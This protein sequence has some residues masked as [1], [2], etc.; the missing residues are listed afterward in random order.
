M[1]GLRAMLRSPGF[2]VIVVALV[3]A[4][5]LMGAR[6]IWDPD[7]GRYTNVALTML[8]SGN[9]IDLS[10]HHESGHWTKPPVTYWA[11]AASIATFG[12]HPWSARLPAA[13]AFL[14]CTWLAWRV[15]RR[16]R[17]SSCSRTTGSCPWATM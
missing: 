5:G 15:A 4:F 7:E 3:L 10:R 2:R 12:P 11:I 1:S 13:L 16:R 8:D 17:A 6:A 9:F 14:A